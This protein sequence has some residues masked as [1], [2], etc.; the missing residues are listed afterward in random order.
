MSQDFKL[1]SIVKES[2]LGEVKSAAEQAHDLGLHHVG[3]GYW[4][5]EQGQ[6]VART[7]TIN[8]KK[9]LVKLESPENIP[10]ETDDEGDEGYENELYQDGIKAL[11][12][13]AA[14]AL[15]NANVDDSVK[16][17]ISSKLSALIG[18]SIN[19]GKVHDNISAEY[20]H[21]LDED[22]AVAIQ[23]YVKLMLD[24]PNSALVKAVKVAQSQMKSDKY[25]GKKGSVTPKIQPTPEP[26]ADITPEPVKPTSSGTMI[27]KIDAKKALEI[28][29]LLGK[30]NPK[31]GFEMTNILQ[32][33]DAAIST[34]QL[35]YIKKK[36]DAADF[37]G[38]GK[39]GKG[40]AAWEPWKKLLKYV[41]STKPDLIV[42]AIEK[43]K[44]KGKNK[45][46]EDSG[47]SEQTLED[48]AQKVMDSYLKSVG[49]ESFHS[50]ENNESKELLKNLII[51][52]LTSPPG[53]VDV[54]GDGSVQVPWWMGT[55]KVEKLNT[56]LN[57]IRDHY[58][59]FAQ[60]VS[61]SEVKLDKVSTA[62]K[63]EY[64]NTIQDIFVAQ[65]DEAKNAADLSLD[66][67]LKEHGYPKVSETWMWEV[68]LALANEFQGT[69]EKAY[70]LEVLEK[71]GTIS[72]TER[73]MLKSFI[74]GHKVKDVINPEADEELNHKAIGAVN[75]IISDTGLVYMSVTQKNQLKDLIKHLVNNP[76]PLGQIIEEL[77][78]INFKT[79]DIGMFAAKLRQQAEKIHNDLYVEPPPV[80]STSQPGNAEEKAA[81]VEL[82]NKFNELPQPIKVMAANAY[83]AFTDKL[84]EELDPEDTKISNVWT[85]QMKVALGMAYLEMQLSHVHKLRADSVISIEEEKILIKTLLDEGFKLSS[86]DE[87]VINFIQNDRYNVNDLLEQLPED[88]LRDFMVGLSVAIGLDSEN[89]FKQAMGGFPFPLNWE[90]T[91]KIENALMTYWKEVHSKEEPEGEMEPVTEPEATP[92]KKK[93]PDLATSLGDFSKQFNKYVHGIDPEPEVSP[94]PETEPEVSPEP[95]TQTVS[96]YEQWE[97]TS[98]WELSAVKAT[99]TAM[100]SPWSKGNPDKVLQ[101]VNKKYNETKAS[102]KD[103]SSWK[104]MA[105]ALMKYHGLDPSSV[106]NY[107]IPDELKGG[108]IISKAAPAPVAP[109][110]QAPVAPTP[111]VEPEEEEEEEAPEPSKVAIPRFKSMSV[112]LDKDSRY[113]N[114]PTG[115]EADVGSF[116]KQILGLKKEIKKL[117]GQKEAAKNDPAKFK[118]ASVSIIDK[119]INDTPLYAQFFTQHKD[120]ILKAV[121][122]ALQEPT[123]EGMKKKLA[124]ALTEKKKDGSPNPNGIPG[125]TYEMYEKLK[126][127]IK[128]T[129][130]SFAAGGSLVDSEIA[131]INKQIND[132]E[133]AKKNV[134]KYNLLPMFD[135]G[136]PEPQP[137]DQLHNRIVRVLKNWAVSSGFGIGQL[138]KGNGER[139]FAINAV[140][141]ALNEKDPAKVHNHIAE[142]FQTSLLPDQIADL[143]KQVHRERKFPGAIA[144]FDKNGLGPVATDKPTKP[145]KVVAPKKT[146]ANDIDKKLKALKVPVDKHA[147][148][149]QVIDNVM[150]DPS[151]AYKMWKIR[152]QLFN[153]GIDAETGGKIGKWAEKNINQYAQPNTQPASEVPPVP[154]NIVPHTAVPATSVQDKYGFYHSTPGAKVVKNSSYGAAI[155]H[156]SNKGGPATS[157]FTGVTNQ[158]FK[159]LLDHFPSDFVKQVNECANW[160][161]GHGQW[162][163]DPQKRKL[164]NEYFTKAIK[165]PPPQFI[166]PYKGYVER[167]INIGNAEEFKDFIQAFAVGELAYIGPS[168]FSHNSSIPRNYTGQ[169]FGVLLRVNGRKSDGKIKG[170]NIGGRHTGPMA[171]SMHTGEH[172]LILG[173]EKNLRT[174]NIIFHETTQG[175]VAVIELD[176]EEDGITEST[177][178]GL[179]VNG[180]KGL[181]KDTVKALIKYMN[182]SVHTKW[183]R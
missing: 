146:V 72:A 106:P 115:K 54:I 87:G 83:I 150:K 151:V 90:D 152:Q 171:S 92:K 142:L 17:A 147:A 34:P 163:H 19:Q 114:P 74:D 135:D 14:H 88:T 179:D 47:V 41:K 42:G 53:E 173:V 118:K 64:L 133:N 89:G 145:A 8:G 153:L 81:E 131:Q 112:N 37:Y 84:K 80:D 48:V 172:E 65:S 60:K 10:D 4:A 170:L 57:K 82:Q 183:D 123:W 124:P 43:G 126:Y 29:G 95:E 28:T 73:E 125:F 158:Q 56:Y 11:N 148:V 26:E 122:V 156:G 33:L 160:W 40:S 177:N 127:E 137:T 75:Q 138:P 161:Q 49:L 136:I 144:Q 78:N 121:E 104:Y 149:K 25:V 119:F 1:L 86:H 155:S 109:T 113:Y 129:L 101:W 111:E 176:Q 182:N 141:K 6:V 108:S 97:P 77:D 154:G 50:Q 140:T 105:A 159:T 94:E 27:G 165:G 55:D 162:H 3:F 103:T 30:L 120:H 164:Y 46:S 96:P 68:K 76:M 102:G 45:A 59:E 71:N 63:E 169:Q 180:W 178:Y 5:N 100:N 66:A 31:Q 98:K 9:V 35:N 18:A 7:K 69:T 20:F 116:D 117:E 61:P 13:I 52:A 36:F 107:L 130:E 166:T 24:H 139:S 167:G 168:G 134:S 44:I 67:F 22:E 157:T 174:K 62:A 51:S 70:S 181:S 128:P 21:E 143:L 12:K 58:P 110:P 15:D 16:Q 39:T 175:V 2:L 23:Q 91:K 99:N 85:S 38:D 32:Q 132:L 79:A 93:V